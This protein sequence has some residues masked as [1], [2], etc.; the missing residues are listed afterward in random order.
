MI[1]VPQIQKDENGV[2][3]FRYLLPYQDDITIK[4]YDHQGMEMDTV[5][6]C[7]QDAGEY[8]IQYDTSKL[9]G[10]KYFYMIKTNHDS[11]VKLMTIEDEK[12]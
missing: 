7:N 5:L 4:I 6:E 8:H 11:V 2:T 3:D 12:R 1:I 9:P 10:G